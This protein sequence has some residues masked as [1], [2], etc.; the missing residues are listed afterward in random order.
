MQCFEAK[1]STSVAFTSGCRFINKT[2]DNPKKH[3]VLH[4]IPR[5]KIDQTVLLLS[6]LGLSIFM[7]EKIMMFWHKTD[8]T[9]QPCS[10]VT[11]SIV[12]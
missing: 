11:T 6:T 9:G 8:K 5:A 7:L 2:G 10:K 4:E 1:N 12:W 3:T